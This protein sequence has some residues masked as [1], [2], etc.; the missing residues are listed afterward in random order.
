VTSIAPPRSTHPAAS[1]R[2]DWPVRVCQDLQGKAR[3]VP[4][5]GLEFCDDPA[6]SQASSDV[7]HPSWRATAVGVYRF[8]RDLGYAAGAL[9]AGALADLF[10]MPTAIAA[11]GVLTAGSGVLVAAR[12]PETRIARKRDGSSSTQIQ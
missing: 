4:E 5:G 12:M 3:H 2:G 7:A 9:L 8:W 1:T 10:G 11:I 6:T